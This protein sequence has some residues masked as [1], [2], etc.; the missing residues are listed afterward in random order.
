MLSL[1]FVGI[2]VIEIL[3]F[4]SKINTNTYYICFQAFLDFF[5]DITSFQRVLLFDAGRSQIE[6]KLKVKTDIVFP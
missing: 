2:S 1:M 3:E 5:S 6:W 4:N